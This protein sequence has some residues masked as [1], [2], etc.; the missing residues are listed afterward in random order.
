MSSKEMPWE[1]WADICTDGAIA[2]M[3]QNN[4]AIARIKRKNKEL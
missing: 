4:G 2:I 3:G 1:S